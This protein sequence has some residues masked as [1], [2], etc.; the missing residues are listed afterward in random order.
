MCCVEMCDLI[1]YG[2]MWMKKGDKKGRGGKERMGANR[3]E[4]V[5]K[6]RRKIRCVTSRA[7]SR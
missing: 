7:V 5:R 4:E 6:K 3:R 1:L 2:A